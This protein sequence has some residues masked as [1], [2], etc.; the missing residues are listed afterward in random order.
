MA[1]PKIARKSTAV[2]MTA[3]CDVAFLLLSFF[4]LT[5]KFKPAEAITVETPSSVSSKVAPEKDVTL[6]SITKDGKTYVSLDNEEVKGEVANQLN[7]NNG[8]NLS[9]SDIAAFKK[10]NFFGTPIS[11]LKSVLQIPT[12]KLKAESLPGIPTQDTAHNEMVAWMRAIVAAHSATGT[13]INILFKG[14]NLAKYPSFKNI[15]TALK[16][17]D[18]FKFQMVTN[19]EGVPEGTDLW[20]KFKSGQSISEE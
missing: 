14:D 11:Q 13:K 10:A 20:K 4:I 3:M 17:N 16:K 9:P 15:L 12:D 2:D 8:A 1:R 5:T 6:I 18:Q 7:A 19:A